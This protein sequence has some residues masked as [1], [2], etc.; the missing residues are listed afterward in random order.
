MKI[1]FDL[2]THTI[3]SGHA[4]SSMQ[5]NIREAYEKGL[6]AYGFSDHAPSMK[7][8]PTELYFENLRI[9]PRTYKTMRVY[10]GAEANIIDY[11]GGLD[12]GEKVY[13]SIDYV[14]ASMHSICIRPGTV[15][16]NTAAYIGAMQNEFVKIIGHPD[17]SRFQFDY[18]EMVKAAVKF[19][20]A[21]ELNNSSLLPTSGRKQGRENILI[22]L[23][24]CKKYGAKI[25]CGSDAHVSFL[26]GNFE[27]SLKI[28]KECDFPEELVLN[29][30]LEGLDYVI[31]KNKYNQ[32]F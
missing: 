27:S 14:I 17:D 19:Q 26:I 13:P 7:G 1:L 8:A 2:H 32:I 31:N 15:E 23:D 12:L 28:L 21:L 20:V 5:E 11:E 9:L 30:S 18:D 16:Q 10:A 25:V 6:S 3:M 24:K 22:L 4:Y 29:T